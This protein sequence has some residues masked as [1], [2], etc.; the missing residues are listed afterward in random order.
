MYATWAQRSECRWGIDLCD[1][2]HE[3]VTCEQPHMRPPRFGVSG[4]GL[5]PLN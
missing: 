1:L 3:L 5:P 4:A 2:Q